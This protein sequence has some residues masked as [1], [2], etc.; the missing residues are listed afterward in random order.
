[1][2]ISGDAGIMGKRVNG[3]LVGV[4]GWIT[5]AVLAVAALALIWFTLSGG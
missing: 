4:V 3:R 5:T 1:M 2:I